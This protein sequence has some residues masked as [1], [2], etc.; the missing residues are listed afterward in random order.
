MRLFYFILWFI[1]RACWSSG[2]FPGFFYWTVWIGIWSWLGNLWRWRAEKSFQERR[3]HG[4][5]WELRFITYN[6]I[7]PLMCIHVLATSLCL[8]ATE[9]KPVRSGQEKFSTGLRSRPRFDWRRRLWGDAWLLFPTAVIAE[10]DHLCSSVDRTCTLLGR[11]FEE[12]NALASLWRFPVW[13]LNWSSLHLVFVLYTSLLQI[14]LL[15]TQ[16]SPGTSSCLK[17]V[18]FGNFPALLGWV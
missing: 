17:G 7:S 5:P 6:S 12:G 1:W 8:S 15:R 14:L 11:T 13:F 9:D 10:K 18:C 4:Y 2:V 16:L 3:P